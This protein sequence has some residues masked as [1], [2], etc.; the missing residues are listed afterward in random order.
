MQHARQFRQ[1]LAESIGMVCQKL[2]IMLDCVLHTQVGAT[3]DM[4][5]AEARD[6]HIKLQV[7]AASR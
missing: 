7:H 5:E 6:L 1:V 2:T 3:I 4:L